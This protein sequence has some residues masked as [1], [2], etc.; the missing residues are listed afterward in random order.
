MHANTHFPSLWVKCGKAQPEQMF[1]DSPQEGYVSDHPP[2]R[3]YSC[4]DV[5][6]LCPRNRL[7][8]RRLGRPSSPQIFNQRP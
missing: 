2:S 3:R 5:G 1:S 8:R 7:E 6:H 4:R